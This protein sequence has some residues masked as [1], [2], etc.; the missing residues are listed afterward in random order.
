MIIFFF[1]YPS[2]FNGPFLKFLI[3]FLHFESVSHPDKSHRLKPVLTN[4]RSGGT[5]EDLSRLPCRAGG[6][7]KR[8]S[9]PLA[10]VRGLQQPGGGNGPLTS[11]ER[12]SDVPKTGSKSERGL[13]VKSEMILWPAVAVSHPE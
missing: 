2:L 3:F 6:R 7:A 8:V 12:Q 5:E 10:G 11:E 1:F 9:G 4:Q 13:R